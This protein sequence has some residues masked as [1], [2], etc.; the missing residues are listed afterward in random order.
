ML[1]GAAI[2]LFHR[3]ELKTMGDDDGV[4]NETSAAPAVT[5]VPE[6][7]SAADGQVSQISALEDEGWNSVATAAVDPQLVA[8]DVSLL[9]AR[10]SDLRK[11][12]ETTRLGDRYLANAEHI[13]FNALESR[14]RVAAINAIGH[15]A[16][17]PGLA[18]LQSVLLSNLAE[19]EKQA[20]LG[21]IDSS[22]LGSDTHRFLMELVYSDQLSESLKRQITTKL[23]V[24]DVL[25]NAAN[26]DV[27]AV[28]DFILALPEPYRDE[29]QKVVSGL[30]QQRG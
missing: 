8:L 27:E 10:E 22:G 25:A 14:T 24:Q 2:T 7:A 1:A 16:S 12:L 30:L 26:T 21:Y 3:A 13:I 4:A 23:I 6:L 11:Q 15:R 18:V 17:G 28:A 20:A 9:A 19:A 29:F 5:R